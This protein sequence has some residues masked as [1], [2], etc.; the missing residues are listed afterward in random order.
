M[1]FNYPKVC[2]PDNGKVS[3]NSGIGFSHPP[4][5]KLMPS[6][7]SGASI[8]V[9]PVRSCSC[10]PLLFRLARLV[11]ASSYLHIQFPAVPSLAIM[12]PITVTEDGFSSPCEENRKLQNFTHE[13]QAHLREG[14]RVVKLE[15]S[16]LALAV[17]RQIGKRATTVLVL[18]LRSSESS[19]PAFNSQWNVTLQCGLSTRHSG[20]RFPFCPNAPDRPTVWLG[21]RRERQSLQKSPTDTTKWTG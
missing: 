4:Q 12:F 15:R 3:I 5:L 18:L 8:L 2:T 6:F 20:S 10:I 11:L 14:V 16:K 13:G 9:V 1:Q 19:P 17:I 21:Q 7:S